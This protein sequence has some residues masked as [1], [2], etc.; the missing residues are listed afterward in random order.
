MFIMLCFG[1]IRKKTL[2]NP[3]SIVRSS[4]IIFSLYFRFNY[5][6]DQLSFSISIIKWFLDGLI[7][8][9]L[10]PKIDNQNWGQ[11]QE[12]GEY[13]EV[14]TSALSRQIS[15]E[16]TNGSKKFSQILSVIALVT[17]LLRSKLIEIYMTKF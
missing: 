2:I 14:I 10:I 12:E 1:F 9:Q 13:D 5:K 8:E 4:E 3:K 17:E 11:Y 6:M 15:L 7:A 16:D